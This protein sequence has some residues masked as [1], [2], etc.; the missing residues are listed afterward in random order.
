MIRVLFTIVAVVAAILAVLVQEPLLFVAS[1]VSLLVSI[2][3]IVRGVQRR[4]SSHKQASST[5]AKQKE[6]ADEDLNA[7]GILEIKPRNSGAGGTPDRTEKVES[8]VPAGSAGMGASARS[9][10]SADTAAAAAGVSSA[11][12]ES[13]SI[14]DPKPFGRS[15]E[16]EPASAE[17]NGSRPRDTPQ[18]TLTIKERS[19]TVRASVD[20]ETSEN[21]RDVLVPYLQSMRAALDAQTVCLL[22]QSD[23]SL[24]Y[25]IE[26]VVS[27]NA[28]ARTGG[29][30]ATKMPL[31]Q[32]RDSKSAVDVR[33]VA[34][35][36]F[37]AANLGYYR[38]AIAVK[39]LAVAAVPRPSAASS[40]LLLADSM[41]EGHFDVP[42]RRTLVNHFAR[43]LGAILE[44]GDSA[45]QL[46]AYDYVRPRREIIVEEIEQA[47]AQHAPLA[48]ALV[49][50]NRAEAVADRGERDVRTAERELASRLRQTARDARVER[51]GELT[52]GVF[53]HANGPEV[54]D[55]AVALQAD[56]QPETDAL[57]G[58]VSIGIALLQERHAN[59]DAFRQDATDALR[60][61]FETGTCTIVE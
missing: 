43:L 15:A 28:Y 41:R 3:L 7:L 12:D 55:W 36:D 56:L 20:E 23:E 30:F 26:A 60:E 37:P 52:Y 32:T 57:E 42:R 27:L 10:E 22:K 59:A 38:D 47:R 21:D 61:A 54:E 34:G 44:E 2:V 35:D 25:H 13:S 29:D 53:F 4:R 33:R 16:S 9:T 45:D 5:Y 49:H 19:Q 51:F 11:A 46:D 31:I 14:A 50:L 1:G 24:H 40:Y 17:R 39:H 8:E 58:G 6:G 18:A 48:L